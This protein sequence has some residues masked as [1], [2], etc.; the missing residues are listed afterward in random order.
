MNKITCYLITLTPFVFSAFAWTIQPLP[1]EAQMRGGD[2]QQFF[3]EGNEQMQQNIQDLEQ[4]REKK[5]EPLGETLSIGEKDPSE[6]QIEKDPTKPE[7]EDVPD[8]G[9]E[10]PDVQGSEPEKEKKE[11][12][13]E[14]T[15]NVGEKDPTKPEV[16]DVPGPGQEKPDIQGSEPEKDPTKP[17]VEDVPGPDQEKMDIQGLEQER[18]KKEETLERTLNVGEKDPNKPEFKDVPGPGEQLGLDENQPFA[19]TDEEAEIK[20]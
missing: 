11:E 17:E 15:P 3:E 14:K 7:V 9:Q 5:E 20:L 6:P 16:E 4:E 10:K 8:P 12:P 2:S 18:E 19:P 13:L 1:A